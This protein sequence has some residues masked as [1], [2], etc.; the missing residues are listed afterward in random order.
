MAQ[1]C[2]LIEISGSPYERGVQYGRQA[3]DEIARAVAHYS[4]QIK[5]N[6]VSDDGL[7][8]VVRAYLPIIENFNHAYVVEMRG[9]AAGA[10]VSF[11]QIVLVNARTELVQ[12]ALRPALL[13]SMDGCTGVVVQPEV[14]RAGQ[15]IHAHNWDW[16]IECADAS[17][18]LRIRNEDGPDILTFT[19]AG[20]LARFGFNAHGICITGNGLECERDFQRPGVPL[21]LIRRKVLEQSNLALALRAA[22][23]TPKSGSN[24]ILISHGPSGLVYDFECAPDE[25]FM[26]EPRDGVLTHANHWQSPIALTKLRETG[27]A[28]AP[29]S[30]YRDRR[31]REALAAKAGDVTIEDVTAVMLDNFESPWSI[32]YPPRPASP[33]DP[34]TYVTVASLIMRPGL[35]EMRVAILPA[36]DPSF[37]C[38]TLEMDGAA[39][40]AGGH[41]PIVLFGGGRMGSAMVRAWINAGIAPDAITVIDPAPSP[42]LLAHG[43]AAGFVLNGQLSAHPGQTVVLAVKPQK[44]AEL[45]SLLRSIVQADTLVI[46]IMAGKTVADLGRLCPGITAFV[47]AMPNLPASVGRGATVAFADAACTGVQRQIATQLLGSTGQLDWLEDEALID[48]ATGLSG[49]GPAYLF[50]I[51]DCLTQAGIAAG[52]P[53]DVAERLVRATVSGSGELLHLSPKSATELRNDVSSPA[54]TTLAG[55]EVLMKNGVLQNLLTGTVAA[56]ADRARGL[57][58]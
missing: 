52:L 37:T 20:G 28:D 46:S 53:A 32:C 48:A 2:R 26:V 23:V 54:G 6:N 18:I 38:Y 7:A 34:K 42:E 45:T 24:N 21:A 13:D 16:Q 19:E 50:Y 1:P 14:T 51:A 43:A 5:S 4:R 57:A 9:I 58:G 31:A 11:E 29:S 56:A 15:L 44:A 40:M 30:F 33:T 27:L 36:L 22:Y 47:R 55:L 17:V 39:R 49:S 12:F 25:T 41:D 8:D 10:G 3:G 35:G